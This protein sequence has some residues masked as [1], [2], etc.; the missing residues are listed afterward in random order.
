MTS[1]RR[2]RTPDW[3]ALLSRIARAQRGPLA[4][5]P[6]SGRRDRPRPFSSRVARQWGLSH[7]PQLRLPTD[8]LSLS[9]NDSTTSECLVIMKKPYNSHVA[10]RCYSWRYLSGLP[11]LLTA[12]PRF[13]TSLLAEH[14]ESQFPPVCNHDRA[15]S[16]RCADHAAA[17]IAGE[18][19]GVQKSAMADSTSV[20]FSKIQQNARD[21]G[22]VS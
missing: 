13:S 10:P 14:A 3:P 12:W 6:R 17:L 8:G 9:G 1:V 11:T 21:S 2:S 20:F 5:L 4:T 18:R 22:A 15:R 7:S 16:R 19:P